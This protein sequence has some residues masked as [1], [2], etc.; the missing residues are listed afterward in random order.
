MEPDTADGL[1]YVGQF[2]GTKGYSIRIKKVLI[3]LETGFQKVEIVDTFD[4]G[5]CLLLDDDLVSCAADEYVYNEAFVHPGLLF[6]PR[7]RNTLLIGVATGAAIREVA[8]HKDLT[9]IMAVDIDRELVEVCSDN[10]P[11]S[12]EALSDPRLELQFGDGVEALESTRSTFD[13]ILVD[14]GEPDVNPISE[15]LDSRVFFELVRKKL[16]DD[17]VFVT[18]VGSTDHTCETRWVVTIR[19]L[20]EVFQHVKLYQT[21]VPSFMT[22]W[23]FALASNRRFSEL[24]PDNLESMLEKRLTSSLR[25]YDAETHSAMFSLPL[26]LRQLLPDK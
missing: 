4:F 13:C 20:R 7:P 10:L 12:R 17:G 11:W 22:T 16:S 8:R 9:R 2:G 18:Q 6:H 3:S 21:F 15:N 24:L 23:G 25:Y 1:W 19:R 5:V 26:P 14:G